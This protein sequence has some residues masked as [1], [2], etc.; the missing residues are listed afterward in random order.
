MT[1]KKKNIWAFQ[2]RFRRHAFGWRS[3]TPIKRIK[4]A[5]SEIKKQARKDPVLAG[6]GAVLF[7]EKISPA[8]E[9]VDSSSGAMGS[10]VNNAIETLVPFIAQAPADDKL[11]DKWLERLWQAIQDD[12]IPYIELLPEYWGQLCA[13]PERAS[14]WADELIDIVR[15]IWEPHYNPGDHFKG[16]DACLSALFAANR[17]DELMALLGNCPYPFWHYRKW[18]VKALVAMGQKGDALRFAEDSRGRNVPDFHIDQ[19]CEAI[20]LESGLAEEAYQRYAFSANQ[21]TTYLATFRAIAKKYPHKNPE[22]LIK[23][24]V[25]NSPGEEG[26]WFAAAKSAGLYED[27]AELVRYFPCDPR[28]LT[29][30]ARDFAETQPLFSVRTGLAALH[31]ISEGY[32]YEITGADVLAAYEHTMAAARNAG[33]EQEALNHIRQLMDSDSSGNA[34]TAHILKRVIKR[35]LSGKT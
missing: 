10:A 22:D 15:Q 19:A 4:E 24:L 33:C 25:L 18:G 16:T 11:R 2:P 31:W 14:F 1:T 12:D 3:Q 21:K 28:T 29:R 26:K 9:N 32:G 35:D 7:L 5:V 20:L 8:I 23:D 6:E 17:F 34:F 30:A 27:A 13:T